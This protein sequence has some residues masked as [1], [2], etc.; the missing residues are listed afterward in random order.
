VLIFFGDVHRYPILWD[1]GIKPLWEAGETLETEKGREVLEDFGRYITGLSA[2]IMTVLVTVV[3]F[4]CHML[5]HVFRVST[6][7][8]SRTA[9]GERAQCRCTPRNNWFT[10]RHDSKGGDV[11]LPV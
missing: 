7:L 4:G 11:N 6:V 9:N 8:L 2:H 5:V 1:L 3:T 10:Q